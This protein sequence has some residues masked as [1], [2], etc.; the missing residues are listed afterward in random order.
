MLSACKG[1]YWI[2]GLNRK[3]AHPLLFN[4]RKQ[5]HCTAIFH[6]LVH[7]SHLGRADSISNPVFAFTVIYSY[8]DFWWCVQAPSPSTRQHSTAWW[9][10]KCPC[11]VKPRLQS[12][13][14]R[15]EIVPD[16]IQA[17]YDVCDVSR[18]CC[19]VWERRGLGWEPIGWGGYI[20]LL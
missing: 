8:Q 1:Q 15:Q 18:L 7:V 12:G 6:I 3:S 17:L 11:D 10:H 9:R 16:A 20:C 4:T 19:D 2:N 13:S 14:G 5:G